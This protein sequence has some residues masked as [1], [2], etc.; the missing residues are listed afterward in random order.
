MKL[1][2]ESKDKLREQIEK[3]LEVVPKGERIKIDKEILEELLFEQEMSNRDYGEVLAKFLV[4][5]DDFLSKLDLSEIS[6]DNMVW[7]LDY[8]WRYGSECFSDK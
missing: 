2:K 4:W 1:N 6:F 3:M 8:S 5:S 7:D